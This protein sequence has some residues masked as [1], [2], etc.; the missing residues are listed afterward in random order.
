M[1]ASRRDTSKTEGFDTL[2]EKLA[3]GLGFR[4]SGCW[5]FG[6]QNL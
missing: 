4:A 2:A 3:E 5:A 1:A 6:M